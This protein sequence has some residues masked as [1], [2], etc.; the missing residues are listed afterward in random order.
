[1]T[2]INNFI[3]SKKN[4]SFEKFMINNN[5]ANNINNNNTNNKFRK[6]ILQNLE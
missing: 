5:I 4:I 2:Q 3:F 6:W 1:M